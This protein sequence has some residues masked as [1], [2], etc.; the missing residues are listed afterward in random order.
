MHIKRNESDGVCIKQRKPHEEVPH[1]GGARKSKVAAKWI[2]A[3]KTG[4]KFRRFDKVR[5]NGNDGFVAGSTN[6]NL[7]LRDIRWLLIP[8]I[9]TSVTPNKVEMLSRHRGGYLIERVNNNNNDKS[10]FN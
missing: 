10:L 4:M 9:K 5:Y 1:K 6:G 7:V 3:K 2:V 8:G